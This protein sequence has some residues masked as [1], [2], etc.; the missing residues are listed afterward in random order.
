MGKKRLPGHVAHSPSARGGGVFRG[1]LRGA[2]G[3]Y[4][5]GLCSGQVS[6]SEFIRVKNLARGTWHTRRLPEVRTRWARGALGASGKF[7]CA[8]A[9]GGTWRIREVSG[10][11]RGESRD[12][13]LARRA[14]GGGLRFR[15]S[16]Q[17]ASSGVIRKGSSGLGYSG[18]RGTLRGK[19]RRVS[20]E[21]AFGVT[22]GRASGT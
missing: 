11:S 13:W 2:T 14:P 22:L 3:R 17:V 7:L 6:H 9:L 5:G 10:F 19:D 16:G 4:P 1:W 18:T 12:T 8:W 15:H 21:S 20:F